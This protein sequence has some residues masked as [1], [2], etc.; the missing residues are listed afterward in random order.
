MPNHRKPSGPATSPQ[1]GPRLGTTLALIC[2]VPALLAFLS[3]AA[4]ALA[5]PAAASLEVSPHWGLRWDTLSY[6]A[7]C[8]T[9]PDGYCDASLARRRL[10]LGPLELRYSY[11]Y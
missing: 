4:P 1:R 11:S 3:V 8:P 7:R 10:C 6:E 5:M 2:G 9:P